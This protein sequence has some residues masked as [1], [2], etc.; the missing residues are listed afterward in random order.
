MPKWSDWLS[1]ERITRFW[2]WG[3]PLIAAIVVLDQLTK[4]WAL[5]VFGEQAMACL[6]DDALPCGDIRLSSVF[7]LTMKWNS[8]ISFGLFGFLQPLGLSWMLFA[9]IGLIAVGFTLWL[10]RAERPLTALALAMVVGGAVGNLIDR[11][12]FGAVVDFLNFGGPWFGW[13]IGDW[14]VGFP[15]IFNVADASI[16]VGAAILLLDQVLVS[17]NRADYGKQEPEPPARAKGG[18]E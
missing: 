16:T 18:V 8:G 7:S 15:W 6:A 14:S 10:F 3:V 17:R 1:S 5:Q 12:R 2:R 11:G 13:R 9:A 4:M